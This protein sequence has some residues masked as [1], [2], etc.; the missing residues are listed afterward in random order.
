M[1]ITQE[2]R[3]YARLA[4]L[5]VFAKYAMEGFGDAI[6]IMSRTGKPFAETMH[7]AAESD[8][9][10]R[11]ALLNVTLAWLALGISGFALYVAL[12]P[13]HRRFAQI[14]LYTRI[15]ACFVGAGGLMLRFAQ[16]RLFMVSKTEGLFTVEQLQALSA[17]LQ[18]GAGAGIQTAWLIQA[19]SSIFFYLLLRRA[20]F[21]PSWV[22]VLGIAS[23]G[24]LIA[25][26]L[27]MFVY[28]QA[29]NWLKLLGLP[30]V[31]ADLMLI[32]WLVF[33]FPRVG[34]QVP[35]ESRS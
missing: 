35:A 28:P 8:V 18:R 9:L 24:F 7:Y 31:I 17:V 19:T 30:G 12:E 23:G 3:T 21:V 32:I 6:T 1:T 34:T 13:V 26:T 22:G 11:F 27:V 10:W 16:A 5:M 20:R 4:G 25:A 14:G 15:G 33:K 2:Q 29:I